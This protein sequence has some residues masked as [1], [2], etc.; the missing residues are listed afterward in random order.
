MAETPEPTPEA[1]TEQAGAEEQAA[2]LT[3]EPA[4]ATDADAAPPDLKSQF[5][6]A[7]ARKNARAGGGE[8]NL[9]TGSKVHDSH[10]RAGGK[11]QFRR[12]SG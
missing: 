9:T 2:A 1:G 10:N 6:A 4:D 5:R 11:R 7:L 8:S 3:A 12:K